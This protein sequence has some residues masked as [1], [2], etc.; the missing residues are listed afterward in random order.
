MQEILRVNM[1]TGGVIR[2]P[3]PEEYKLLGGRGLSSRILLD[4]VPPECDPLGEENKLIFAV[5]LMGGANISSADRI[6]IGGKSPLTGGIKETNGG[7]VT[8]LRLARLGLRAVIIEGKAPADKLFYLVLGEDKA[9]LHSADELKGLGVFDTANA[10]QAKW[11]KKAGLAIIG[12]AG[13]RE[14][15]SAGIANAD[16][17]GS[18][19]RYCGRGGLGAVMGSKGLKALVV[20]PADKPFKQAAADETLWKESVRDYHQLLNTLPPTSKVMPIYGTNSGMDFI[21]QVGGLPTRNFSQGQFE[22]VEKINGE[23]LLQVITERGGEGTPTHNCM[24]GCTVRCSNRYPD[25]NGKII[26][27]PLEYESIALLGANLGIGDLDQIAELNYICNDLGVDTIE[28]GAALGVAADAGLFE[29]GDFEQAR[30]YLLEIKEGTVTGRMLGQGTAVTGKVLG[31]KRVPVVKGQAMAGYD[32]RYFKGNGVLYA[33]S[34][35]GADH[36]CG[37]TFLDKI[38]HTDPDGKIEASRR[39]QKLFTVIDTLGFCLFVNAAVKTSPD[40]FAKLFNAR[41]GTSYTFDDLLQIIGEEVIA[42]ELEFNRR[43]GFQPKDDRLPEFMRSEPLS[44]SN[45]VWDVPDEAIDLIW[46]KKN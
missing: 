29:F 41:Y 12:P 7:G 14:Y 43:A 1:N 8:A 45:S 17:D 16:K 2:Q 4:E 33:T 35:M 13:E 30:A 15:C 28:I 38:E 11:G 40:L 32:P 20:L 21:N 19:T 42:G 34:P 27:E 23:K 39:A 9:E 25:A 37:N 24:P 5:G 3:L 44:P 46:S 10:L 31:A 6:S 26:C 36:T 22:E 18:P